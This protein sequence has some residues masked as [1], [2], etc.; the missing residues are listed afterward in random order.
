MIASLRALFDGLTARERGLLLL[1]AALLGAV[2]LTYGLILPLGYAYDAARLRVDD[3]ARRGAAVLAAARTLDRAGKPVRTGVL[4][5]VGQT[6]ATAAQATGIVLQS[7]EPVADP[8]GQGV[9][10]AQ[11]VAP[12]A[13]TGAA[14]RWLDGLTAQ[15][16][17]IESVTMTPLADGSVAVRATIRR[18]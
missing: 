16:L 5:A 12:Q 18:P 7:T 6:V 17:V 15:G 1:A 3:S 13:G 8:A 14:L 2:L 10:G 4:P 9:A 11:V